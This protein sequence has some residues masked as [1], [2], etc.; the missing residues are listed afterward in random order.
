MVHRNHRTIKSHESQNVWDPVGTNYFRLLVQGPSDS[1]RP[2]THNDWLH[3]KILRK[4]LKI[5]RPLPKTYPKLLPVMRSVRAVRR[6]PGQTP[7]ANYV[8]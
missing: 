2:Y 5:P 4:V 3:M 6:R 7:L 1:E 8:K